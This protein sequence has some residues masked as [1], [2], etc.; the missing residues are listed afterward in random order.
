MPSSRGSSRPRNRT[1]DSCIAGRFFTNWAMREAPK[2]SMP[3]VKKKTEARG[4]VMGQRRLR[5]A[6]TLNATS[7]LI[8]S[9]Q[10]I[11]GT[12]TNGQ[13]AMRAILDGVNQLHVFDAAMVTVGIQ[14]NAI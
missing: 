10:T 5:R 3:H 13:T 8:K 11:Q 6:D 7:S 14:E 2:I 1:R 4:T 12:E 9:D